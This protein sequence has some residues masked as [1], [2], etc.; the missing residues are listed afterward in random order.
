ML[1]D[2]RPYFAELTDPRRTTKNKLH[3]LGD[4][5]FIVLCAVLSGI[6]DWVG[7]EEFAAA[8]EEWLRRYIELPGG[9]PSHDTLSDVIGRI[10]PKQFAACFTEWV[11]STL[12]SL[13]GEHIAIDGK[14]LRG[15][16]YYGEGAVHM[17]S[18]F[19]T[20]AR[21]VLTQSAVNEKSNEIK[22]IPDLL[23][24]L[25]LQ[26][27]M[28]SI[29]AMGCQKAIAE[30]IT[31]AGADYVL[32]LKENQP[33]LHDAV[34]AVIEA[35]NQAGRGDEREDTDIGRRVEIRRC[36]F[37]DRVDL[38]IERYPEAASWAGLAAFGMVES[39]RDVQGKVSVERRYFIASTPNFVRFRNTVRDHW[40]IENTEHWILD[41]QFGEDKN[42]SRKNS[43]A[44]NLAAIRRMSLNLLQENAR[45]KRPIRRRK[46]LAM[47]DDRYRESLLF[48]TQTF[49]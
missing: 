48:P 41:V 5:V 44:E 19:A 15:S 1:S 30:Q 34:A 35:E 9:L 10:N 29:D 2:P 38:L 17:M 43:S 24:C 25:N 46:L 4:I 23:K 39:I 6:E 7:M 22:A 28:I 40:Q 26:G 32:A 21:L 47:L 20:N 37:S 3:R 42:R 49:S 18:A 13:A 27:A 14:T 45:D 12:P 31:Q 33:K 36:A 8:K 16:S 11:R